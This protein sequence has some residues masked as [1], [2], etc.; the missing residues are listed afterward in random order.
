ML[1]KDHAEISGPQ[2]SPEIGSR[3]SLSDEQATAREASRSPTENGRDLKLS[4]E[5]AQEVLTSKI[6]ETNINE[7]VAVDRNIVEKDEKSSVS[8][9]EVIERHGVTNHH[10]HFL[11][12]L[13]RDV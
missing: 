8:V 4:S 6:N 11:Y 1:P 12:L 2:S 5:E 9:E 3:N 7:E 10:N 13:K